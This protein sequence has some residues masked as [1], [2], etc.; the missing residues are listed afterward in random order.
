MGLWFIYLGQGR[1]AFLIAGGLSLASCVSR[2]L[3]VDTDLL[4]TPWSP[5]LW[6][7]FLQKQLRGERVYLPESSRLQKGKSQGQEREKTLH[8]QVK[9][10]SQGIIDAYLAEPQFPLLSKTRSMISAA[11]TGQDF[12]LINT[13]FVGMPRVQ[14]HLDNAS[15]S[16]L[17]RMI[18]G[19]LNWQL[20]AIII[21]TLVQI[22][23]SLLFTRRQ[24]PDYCL[25][26]YISLDT[27][28]LMLFA[29]DRIF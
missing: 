11:Q 7:S 23:K 4:S 26:L 1:H 5:Y 10:D 19:L 12:T 6:S 9:A 8:S 24:N 13:T 29:T 17:P 2:L 14:P 22:L 28:W 21:S 3:P 27:T 25:P 18:P 20:K 15:L 16:H